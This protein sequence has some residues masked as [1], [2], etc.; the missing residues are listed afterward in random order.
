MKNY[1]FVLPPKKYQL[2][3][4]ILKYCQTVAGQN[5]ILLEQVISGINLDFIKFLTAT[6][7]CHLYKKL[8]STFHNYNLILLDM[9]NIKMYRVIEV[10]SRIDYYILITLQ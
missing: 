9:S 3:K 2:P 8:N 6:N 5:P 7:S 10:I 4:R 1:D